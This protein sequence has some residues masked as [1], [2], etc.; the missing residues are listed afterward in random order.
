[1]NGIPELPAEGALATESL[2][3]ST[4]H[5][6]GSVAK[7]IESTTLA[8]SNVAQ[9]P[10]EFFD[11]DVISY[12]GVI[13]K[14]GYINLSEIIEG[15]ILSD[16]KSKDVILV[17]VTPGG[18]PDAGF[19]IG[20]A[21]N[22][23][24]EKVTIL[25]PDICKSAG[26]LIAVAANELI[27]GDLGELG[28]LDIQLRKTD[29]IGELTSTLDIF[30]SITELQNRT[31]D[32]FRHYVTDIKYGSGIG[33]KLASEIASNLTKAVI[34]PISAQIDPI[35]IGEHHRALQIAKQYAYRLNECAD[36][37]QH[38]ALKR[39]VEGYP[40]HSFVIDRREARK[41][42]KRVKGTETPEE[43]GLYRLA[44]H[45]LNKKFEEP[46]FYLTECND[47]QDFTKV[48]L[49]LSEDAPDAFSDNYTE[50][51]ATTSD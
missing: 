48:A 37:L 28:P 42:F 29:E 45:Y 27:I 4:S 15:K 44:R 12:Y 47:V 20:R 21:L 1:M 24:Y 38:N 2:E 22:H 31:L 34:S 46:H 14:V 10:S 5:E 16:T 40:C 9:E 49:S 39:L 30:K 50:P 23:H 13:D 3:T 33:T 25:I 43:E 26:T 8:E 51:A 18:D 41:I 35:K 32:C 7:D 36:N 19:R 17:L 11:C 6:D